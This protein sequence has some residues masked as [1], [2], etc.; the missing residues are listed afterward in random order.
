M[1]NFLTDTLNKRI[2]NK[3]IIKN[4]I[5]AIA[6][7]IDILN[8]SEIEVLMNVF[9]F[10]TKSLLKSLKEVKSV[11][12]KYDNLSNEEKVEVDKI[13]NKIMGRV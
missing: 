11:S 4:D 8:K 9:S 6:K 10:L 2:N 3:R 13:V 1:S 12:P 7:I 5:L